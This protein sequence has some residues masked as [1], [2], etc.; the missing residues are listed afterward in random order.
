MNYNDVKHVINVFLYSCSSNNGIYVSKQMFVFFLSKNLN[1][2]FRIIV[3]IL[4]I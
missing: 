3:G 4:D 2:C 1:F